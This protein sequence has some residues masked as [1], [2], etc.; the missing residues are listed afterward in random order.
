MDLKE[1]KWVVP[2]VRRTRSDKDI[3]T[4]H[5]PE[6]ITEPVNKSKRKAEGFD[7][8]RETEKEKKERPEVK[9][10][11]ETSRSG[12]ERMREHFRD[13]ENLSTSSHMLKHF[14]EKH[15]NIKKEDMRFGV[16]ILRSYNSAFERQIGESVWINDYLRNGVQ[17]MNSRN[18]YNRCII[19]RLR[20]DLGKD[21]DVAAFEE[22][23]KE[24]EIKREI[25]RLK[26][27]MRYEKEQQKEKKIK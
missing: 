20:I 25:Y 22:T 7:S 1:P 24:K 4:Y 5:R 6:T 17:M 19:P 3:E 16:K 10:V 11:G 2:N 23:E 15:R 9:Y 26:E 27:K 13:F 18:E 14:I 8:L 21:E 12:Y